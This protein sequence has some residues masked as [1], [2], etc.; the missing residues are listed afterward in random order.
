MCAM[1]NGRTSIGPLYTSKFPDETTYQSHFVQFNHKDN[2]RT[3]NQTI[4]F[5]KIIASI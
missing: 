4:F 1:E 2:I 5:P 3:N